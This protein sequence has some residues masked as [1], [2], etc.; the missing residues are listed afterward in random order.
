MKNLQKYSSVE[1][2]INDHQK[3]YRS[4]GDEKGKFTIDEPDFIR[5]Q[6]IIHGIGNPRIILDIGCNDGG[7][8]RLLQ[9][10]GIVVYGC[11]VVRELVEIAKC[12]GVMAKVCPVEK[13]DYK[14]NMF[15]VVV[16]AEVLEHL[17][18]PNE[19]LKQISRVLK[20]NGTFVGSV[21]H[22]NG[23]LGIGKKADYHNWIY[24]EKDLDELFSKYF[25]TVEI[26]ETPYSEKF[27]IET[28]IDK[29]MPNWLNWVCKDK[30][31]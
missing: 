5:I 29:N 23:H 25:K 4:K 26:T 24:E 19:A 30:I 2:E 14:D 15:D 20:P 17:F 16:L 8:G 21:P 1:D 11:D 27:C 13:L 28:N 22:P 6:K 10:K 31:L 3:N 18:D 12:K 7:L 9:Q